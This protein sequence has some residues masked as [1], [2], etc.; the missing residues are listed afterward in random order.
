MQHE[1][2]RKDESKQE[3]HGEPIAFSEMKFLDE[4]VK[5]DDP[6]YLEAKM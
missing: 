4:N 6:Y 1:S 2:G 5:V 3:R